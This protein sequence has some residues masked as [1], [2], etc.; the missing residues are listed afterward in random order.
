MTLAGDGV[1]DNLSQCGFNADEC[2]KG[3]ELDYD[4][5]HAHEHE[6]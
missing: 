5:E 6:K 1:R 4:Y 3:P 2:S